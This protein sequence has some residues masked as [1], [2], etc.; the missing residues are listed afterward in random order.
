[1]RKGGQ[2][3]NEMRQEGSTL[4]RTGVTDR[5]VA[6]TAAAANTTNS[7]APRRDCILKSMNMARPAGC[8]H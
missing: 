6:A 2:T 3:G 8:L 1:M 5:S 7:K 4:R